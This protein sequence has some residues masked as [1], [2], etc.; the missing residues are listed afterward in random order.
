[1]TPRPRSRSRMAAPRRDPYGLGVTTVD[2]DGRPV[3]SLSAG[4]PSGLPEI[5]FMAGLGAPG[6]LVPWVRRTSQWTRATLLDLPGWHRAGAT[7]SDASLSGVVQAM[8]RWLA[9][10]DRRDVVLVGHSTGAQAVLLAAVTDPDRLTG[11][12]LAGPSFDPAART[13][14]GV[15]RRLLVTVTREPLGAAAVAVPSYVRSWGLPLLRFVRSALHDRPEDHVRR[16]RAPA[17]VL[18]AE[19]DAFCPPVWGQRLADLTGAPC[20]VLAGAHMAQYARPAAADELLHDAVRRWVRP[21]PEAPGQ[22]P[23]VP[24]SSSG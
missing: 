15:L 5:V 8:T 21:T 12:V 22:H 4:A 3:R 6:Y 11:V 9:V 20:H 13:V 24:G 17:L 14:P 2:V 10:T 16:L 19:A 18:T 1:V 7:S 23:V